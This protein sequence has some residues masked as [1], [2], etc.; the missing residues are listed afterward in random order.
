MQ[1]FSG[2]NQMCDMKTELDKEKETCEAQIENK[3][4]GRYVVCLCV[5]SAF[6]LPFHPN[7]PNPNVKRALET[8]ELFKRAP[9]VHIGNMF[10]SARKPPGADILLG[11]M[12]QLYRPMMHLE[13]SGGGYN[14]LTFCVVRP[15]QPHR[16]DFK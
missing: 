16:F 15:S 10:P 5:C 4:A 1:V 6:L 3:T 2:L 12:M 11:T 13:V 14:R 8:T 7:L 9:R